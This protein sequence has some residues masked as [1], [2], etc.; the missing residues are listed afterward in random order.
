MSVLFLW[1]G[2]DIEGVA[3]AIVIAYACGFL[4]NMR[5]VLEILPLQTIDL[6]RAILPTVLIAGAMAACVFAAKAPLRSWLGPDHIVLLLL[7]LIL[8]GAIVYPALLLLTARPLVFETLQLVKE[9]IGMRKG[10]G[11]S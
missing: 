9:T 10:G 1:L 6:V 2:W 5:R 3:L 11:G 7:S 4:Y 8:V